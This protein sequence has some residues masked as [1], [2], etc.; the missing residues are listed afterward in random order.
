VDL[1]EMGGELLCAPEDG[2]GLPFD[3]RMNP[4]YREVLVRKGG[5]L[6]RETGGDLPPGLT[7]VGVV[8]LYMTRC[9]LSEHGAAK[10]GRR[11][12]QIRARFLG[13]EED[14]GR[15]D[16]SSDRPEGDRQEPA[17]AGDG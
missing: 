13:V 7:I 5:Q 16:D 8:G 9:A 11:Y 17:G 12:R 15:T 1:L 3:G 6:L 4:I 10:I 2:P 14:D